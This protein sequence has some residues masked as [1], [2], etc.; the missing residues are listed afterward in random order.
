MFRAARL[1]L[2]CACLLAVARP[3]SAQFSWKTG[4]DGNWSV[5]A[6]WTNGTAPTSGTAA[7]LTFSVPAGG[8]TA[9]NDIANP[10]IFQGLTF[11]N[12][13]GTITLAG[14]SLQF[15]GSTSTPIL[16]NGAG[17]AVIEN[18]ISPTSV[19]ADTNVRFGGT[20]TGTLTLTQP[21]NA[22]IVPGFSTN[23]TVSFPGTVFFQGGGNI[24][25]L[26]VGT[27]KVNI[28]AQPFTLG[29]TLAANGLQVSG[30][31]NPTVQVTSTSLTAN[32]GASQFIV[33]A[34][35]NEMGTL[36]VLDSGSVSAALLVIGNG[37]SS[38][39]TVTVNGTGHIDALAN[40]LF[41]SNPS[42]AVVVGSQGT[43]TLTFQG[44]GSTRVAA[45]QELRAFVGNNPGSN[46]TL[47]VM[48]GSKPTFTTLIVG[49][50]AGSGATPSALGTVLVD[51]TNSVLTVTA[52]G[53]I[54]SVTNI[55]Q[56]GRGSI[57]VQ[58]GGS[59][60]LLSSTALGSDAGSSGTMTIDNAT[61]TAATNTPAA[62]QGQMSMA[63]GSGGTGNL[64]V[65]NGGSL[66]V[67]KDQNNGLVVA[68]NQG[69]TGTI[70]LTGA[71]SRI[72]A[73]EFAMSG[74]QFNGNGTG[75]TSMLSVSSGGVFSVNDVAN[76]GQNKGGTAMI[77]VDGAGSQ[78]KLTGNGTTN[79]LGQLTVGRFNGAQGT[80]TVQNGGSLSAFDAFL[81]VDANTNGTLTVTGANSAATVA[82][83]LLIGATANGGTGAAGVLN[84]Q[85]GGLVDNSTSGNGAVFVAA[86]AGTTGTVTVT[87]TNSQLRT[88]SL[89][90]TG[91]QNVG[92]GTGGPS[93]L[94]VSAGGSVGVQNLA[95]IGQNKGGTA[96]V[97]V[98]GAGSQFQ[99]TGANPS[100]SLVIGAFTGA[101]GVMTVQNGGRAS[102]A[103]AMLGSQATASGTLTVTGATSTAAFGQ[104]VTVGGGGAGVLTVA[105]NAQVTIGAAGG[106]A[107]AVGVNAGGT[108]AGNGT[109][110]GTVLVAP[111]G[112]V[113]PGTVGTV[114]TLSVVGPTTFNA[115]SGTTRSSYAWDIGNAGA[116]S[117]TSGGSDTA[118][119]HDLLT[120][121]GALS[122]NNGQ[123][124]VSEL[125]G[126]AAAFDPSRPYSWTIASVT[127]SG[128]AVTFTPPGLVALTSGSALATAVTAGRGTVAL[129]SA[130]TAVYLNY[131]PVPEPAYILL[132]CAAAAAGL[133]AVRR[134]SPPLVSRPSIHIR[135]CCSMKSA[136]S[137]N[138]SMVRLAG[139]QPIARSN[140]ANKCG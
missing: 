11:G 82:R 110:N 117:T 49:A 33:G 52:A 85:A 35:A 121:N 39:G 134:R 83:Q 61:V 115:P 127:G 44:G 51:G 40:G 9:T 16:I 100:G 20:G 21:F 73:Y 46:G 81:G 47:N 75:G 4:V 10:F 67:G 22:T 112:Q 32:N 140:S 97:T 101:T 66:T 107:G 105:S 34:L 14:Q 124:T 109:V 63:V 68:A 113:A 132:A 1:F 26:T 57:T 71:N 103:T 25:Q 102:A 89:G 50:T 119:G 130:A 88:T 90:M 125:T 108:L 80:I 133:R 98:D 58:N 42:S 28:V 78:F 13:S 74:T 91:Q 122:F 65:Q 59:A 129:T 123:L 126:F 104:L 56:T 72:S 128:N 70:N 135:P 138:R 136:L 27:G 62:G 23:A 120:V 41:Q 17:S 79:L 106:T 54:T 29:R 137:P 5:G 114:G 19:I 18:T 45:D 12:T 31:S 15:D 93:T 139:D 38:T 131:Q 87:G 84:V 36:N 55:G 53:T 77:T 86:D 76:I 2:A 3:A 118:G 24:A 116:S 64:T 43:G 8:F 111:G 94:T 96:T 48:S 95:T 37:A 92:T 7:V 6:N 30:T 69:S 60:Q 99:L